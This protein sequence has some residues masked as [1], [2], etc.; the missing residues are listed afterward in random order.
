MFRHLLVRAA[1]HPEVVQGHAWPGLLSPREEKLL[2]GLGIVPRRRKWLL[3]RIA[4]KRLV[5]Q[6][7]GEADLVDQ[8]ISVL[9]QPSG[10]PFVLIE[11]RGGWAFPI[12]LSHRSEVGMAA[13]PVDRLA[14]IGADLE[15]VEPRD[16]ALIR[17]FFTDDEAALVE[18]SGEEPS[19]VM[20]RIWSAKEAVLKLLGLGLRIDTRGVRVSL[21]GEPFPGCPEGWQPVTVAVLAKLPRQEIL[22]RLRVVWRREPECVL[23]VACQ[24]PPLAAQG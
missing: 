22:E 19:L 18:H 2:A 3:G 14:R 24:W 23:T 4:A 16:P 8:Q 13:A 1:E 12:S 20:A 5:R 11:G 17:Q 21:T 15:T 10:E 6:V 7:S 9:N